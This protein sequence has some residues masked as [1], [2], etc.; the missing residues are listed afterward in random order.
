ML[1]FRRSR[2]LAFGLTLVLVIAVFSVD[3]TIKQGDT[4]GQIA[5]DQGVSLSDLIETNGISNPDL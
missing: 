3:Y 1:K 2:A 4:L 5:R